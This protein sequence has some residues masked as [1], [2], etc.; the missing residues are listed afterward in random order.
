MRQ[1]ELERTRISNR[2]WDTALRKQLQWRQT[3]L[4][5]AA[6]VARD[7]Q[8]LLELLR[9]VDAA[10][11]RMEAGTFGICETC[12]EPVEEERLLQDPLCRNCLGHLSPDEQRALERDLDLAFQVQRGLL[13]S[14]S[15]R[16]DGWSVAWHYEPAGPVSGD[17]CDLIPL[18]GD[19]ALFLLGDV[20]GKGVAASML[21]ANLHATFRSLATVCPQVTG[22]VSAANRVFCKT[23]IASH[24][25]TLVC[26]R[27]DP[28]GTI[29]LCNA[30]HC[31][32]LHV[33]EGKA[34]AIPSDGLPLG[35][36]CEGEYDSRTLRVAR[37]DALVLYSDGLSDAFCGT[38][39]SYGT[40]R[41][42]GVAERHS[43]LGAKDLLTAILEDLKGFRAGGSKADDLTVMVLRREV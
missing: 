2:V 20:T 37:G 24:F 34:Q 30:G 17:Y 40:K 43:G 21:M 26:G 3:R 29:E 35:L 31:L 14:Q 7:P 27:L 32:P 36:V 25:A 10:L 16:I 5:D 23:T 6:P 15:L 1:A 33:H 38:G 9:Q 22:L 18:E 39:E 8:P 41:L 4:R 19:R 42:A 28:Q 11:D 12:H 13:P